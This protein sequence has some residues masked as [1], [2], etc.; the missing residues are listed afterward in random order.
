[1][2]ETETDSSVLNNGPVQTTDG[3]GLS[4]LFQRRR[5]NSDDDTSKIEAASGWQWQPGGPS[6][7][8]VDEKSSDHL[9]ADS[10][11]GD[12]VDVQVHILRY[13]K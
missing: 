5:K 4:E 6:G 12:S 7:K 10:I 11:E 3:C 13:A 9:L 1:M 8:N 2:E